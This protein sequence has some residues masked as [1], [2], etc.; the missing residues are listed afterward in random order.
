M[1]DPDDQVFG[2]RGDFAVDQDLAQLV[3]EG[4]GVPTV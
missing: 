2:A 4:F 1:A 3:A